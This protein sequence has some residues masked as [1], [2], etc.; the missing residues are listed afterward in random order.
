MVQIREPDLDARE[1]TRF[2]RRCVT[3]AKE[4]RARILVN[5]RLDVALAAGAHGVHLREQSIALADARR[6]APGEFLIG[7]SVHSATTA[8]RARS[9]D[10]MIT[11]SVFETASKPGQSASLGVGGL[12]D[13]VRAAGACPVWAV[14]GITA[15]RAREIVASG[16]SGVAA[17]GAFLPR[18]QATVV[19]VEVQRMTEDLRLSFDSAVELP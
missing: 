4:S 17:I 5:D 12:R 2:V 18:R 3:A 7:R 10:Y 6:L 13:V 9:A 11:G 8:A 19:S 16:A 1:L 15:N 14:G